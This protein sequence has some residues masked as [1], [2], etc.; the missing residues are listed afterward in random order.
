MNKHLLL[1]ACLFAVVFPVF[2][3]TP[4]PQ[5][6]FVDQVNAKWKLKDYSAIEQLINTR[7]QGNPNDVLALGTKAYYHFYAVNDLNLSRAAIQAFNDLV[8]AS[9]NASAKELAAKMKDEIWAVPLS[10]SGPLPAAE[11]NE[12]HNIFPKEMPMIRQVLSVEKAL[13]PP[14][15]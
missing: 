10:E 15:P 7:L 6:Q 1:F 11:Q 12:F 3:Q 9:N 4:D 13:H 8:Q 2:G 14:S 5:Q